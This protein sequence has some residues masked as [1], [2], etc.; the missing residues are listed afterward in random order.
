M[1]EFTPSAGGVFQPGG[2]YHVTGDWRFDQ[3][4][5]LGF[6]TADAPA[7]AF[8][9]ELTLGFYRKETNKLFVRG[10]AD[11]DMY[12][13]LQA[14]DT[15]EQ[16]AYL[17]FANRDGFNE[18]LI[19]KNAQTKFILYE[20]D[21]TV[22]RMNLNPSGTTELNSVGT[23]PVRI[24][25]LETDRVAALGTGGL[26]VWTGGLTAW[27]LITM[28]TVTGLSMYTNFTDGANYD[29]GYLRWLGNV[30]YLGTDAAGTGTNRAVGIWSSGSVA[31]TFGGS[32][33]SLA[34]TLIF[35]TDN[36]YDIGAATATRPRHLFQTGYH[37][38]SEVA[39]P[40][41]P[42]AN[43]ARLYARDNGSGKTQLTVVFATGAVQVLATEP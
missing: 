14:G 24:N 27:P 6:G 12:F 2:D 21:S 9:E 35:S 28:N 33:M 18:W 26:E 17:C 19:G 20:N 10:K 22:H 34:R 31:A 38:F 23:N 15:A 29:R 30:L 36:T 3:P 25:F 41:A 39:D 43:G 32:S 16:R 37:Q 11:A 40:A 4:V 8:A 7:V 5:R 1:P 13:G 42:A